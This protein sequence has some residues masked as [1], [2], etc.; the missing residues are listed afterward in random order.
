MSRRRLLIAFAVVG[1]IAAAEPLPSVPLSPAAVYQYTL[2]PMTDAEQSFMAGDCRIFPFFVQKPKAYAQKRWADGKSIRAI[3]HATV[4]DSDPACRFTASKFLNGNFAVGTM[5]VRIAAVPLGP[6]FLAEVTRRYPAG[7]VTGHGLPA[8][9]G[10]G[11]YSSEETTA[12]LPADG[13]DYLRLALA[14]WPGAGGGWPYPASAGPASRTVLT[15]KNRCE[16]YLLPVQARV[17][18]HAYEAD[19]PSDVIPNLLRPYFLLR[20][21]PRAKPDS[22]GFS[23]ESWTAMQKL[24]PELAGADDGLGVV[25]SDPSRLFGSE[26]ATLAPTAAQPPPPEA[27]RPAP[28][29][30]QARARPAPPLACPVAPS[31]EVKARV[32]EWAERLGFHARIVMEAGVQALVV[33]GANAQQCRQADLLREA[34]K[35]ATECGLALAGVC[36]PPAETAGSEQASP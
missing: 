31:P 8:P 4:N 25:I 27:A 10:P 6:E 14:C 32:T 9:P 21:E 22:D 20:G 35:D 24:V 1:R 11:L 36:A 17:P 33:E 28:S 18:Q 12:P 16:W 7:L 15:E 26:A 29:L 2:L 19:A 23:A 13:A 30:A 5:F 3:P 34:V